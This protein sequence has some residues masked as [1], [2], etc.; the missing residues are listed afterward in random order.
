MSE[1]LSE[2][3]RGE[4]NPKAKANAE[5]VLEIARL[6]QTGT[7]IVEL[8]KMFPVIS[9]QSISDIVKG[10]TWGHLTGIERKPK[11]ETNRRL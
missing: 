9:T 4:R 7:K 10:R 6:Y 5:T 8:A 1:R 2:K 11:M 3:K